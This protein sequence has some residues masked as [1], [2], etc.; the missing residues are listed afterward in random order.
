[1]SIPAKSSVHPTP[2]PT[3]SSS[4]KSP[5]AIASDTATS[6]G[7]GAIYI[8]L[9]KF[10]FIFTGYAIIFTLPRLLTKE[11]YG[12]YAVVTS[13]VSIINAVIITGTQQA[14]SKFVSENPAAA[15]GLRSR[16]LGVQ[17]ILGTLTVLV[18]VLLTPYLATQFWNDA[19]LITPLRV[20]ALI[21][22][23]YAFYAVY[24]GYLNGKKEFFWQAT[25]D[26][27]YSTFKML[28]IIACALV[29]RSVTGAVGGFALGAFLVLILAIGLAG[30][31]R[32]TIAPHIELGTYLTFQLPLLAFV[33]C[34]NLLQK[35][36]IAFLK[37]FSSTDPTIASA[38]AGDYGALINIANITYQ[39]VISVTFVVFPLISKASFEKETGEVQTYIRQTMRV[40]LLVMALLATVF[41]SNAADSLGLL[42]P[43]I[44]LSGA[45][46]LQ[47][48]AFG[49]LSFGLISVLTTIITGSGHPWISLFIGAF[50]LVANV[51]LNYKLIPV[52]GLRG[53]AMGTTISMTVGALLA[54]GYVLFSFKALISPLT[55]GRIVLASVLIYGLHLI[56]LTG[57]LV[58]VKMTIQGLAYLTILIVTRELGAQE[59]RLIQK[60]FRLTR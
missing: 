6:A 4:P 59:L 2:D 24:M 10:Y 38:N 46:A 26:T 1:M 30:R 22:L 55:L 54:C 9:A 31:G 50:T 25:L 53:A 29:F 8:T 40:A 28:A 49:M 41:S 27:S 60:I 47:I 11:Q 39:A 17:G 51:V 44:Y 18:Y 56:P 15:E 19:S 20:S 23:C 45:G 14:V 58:V 37:A 5:S 52:Y 3:L 43:K 33:L 34:N 12:E 32:S 48:V 35:V 21:T 36:D 42:Y 57:V 7:R 16:A 13:F